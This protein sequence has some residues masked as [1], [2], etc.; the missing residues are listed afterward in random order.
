VEKIKKGLI[1]NAKIKRAYYRTLKRE[2][3]EGMLAPRYTTNSETQGVSLET[4]LIEG[5]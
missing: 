1:Q 3:K 5:T 4:A 2:E